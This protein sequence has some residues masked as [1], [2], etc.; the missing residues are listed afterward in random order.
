MPKK[1]KLRLKDLKVQSFVTQLG[2]EIRRVKGGVSENTL[3]ILTCMYPCGTEETCET[4][5]TCETC[6]ASCGG[7]CTC[8]TCQ[9]SCG[10]TCE[11]SICIDCTE[12]PQIIC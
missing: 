7:T 8:D 3:C 11:Y 9:H 2:D 12:P 5:D 4:C 6:G 10:G 1:M